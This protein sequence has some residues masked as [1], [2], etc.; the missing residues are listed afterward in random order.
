M[1]QL[2]ILAVQSQIKGE[3]YLKMIW[4]QTILIDD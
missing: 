3:D 4:N 2:L 1:T